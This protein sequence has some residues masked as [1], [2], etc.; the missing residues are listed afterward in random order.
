MKATTSL[1][2]L[3]ALSAVSFSAIGGTPPTIGG[4]ANIAANIEGGIVNAGAGASGFQ[5]TVKQA[6]ASVLTGSVSGGLKLSVD[7]KGG[8]VNVGAGAE[9]AKIISCQSVG[10]IGSDC[11]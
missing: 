1:A 6:V 8:I 2:A 4:Q 11:N 9:G 5:G 3:V 10:T 7:L